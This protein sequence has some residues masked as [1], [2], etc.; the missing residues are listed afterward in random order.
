[1]KGEDRVGSGKER[2]GGREEGRFQFLTEEGQAGPCQDQGMKCS[3]LSYHGSYHGGGLGGDGGVSS[4]AAY[5]R[6]GWVYQGGH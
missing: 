6:D 2:E 4:V 5:G 3:D 1:M